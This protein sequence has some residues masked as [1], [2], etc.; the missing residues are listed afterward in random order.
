VA[1]VIYTRAL[2]PWP[3]V[4]WSGVLNFAGV[5]LGGLAV[6]YTVVD[7]I[8]P[9]VLTPPDG[10]PALGMLLALF[11]SAIIW[12]VGTWCAPCKGGAFQWVQGPPGDRSSRKQSGQSWR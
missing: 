11:A 12:N 6:A 8:P 4:I 1:T 2:D 9:E 3:A 7:L 10:N 5:L